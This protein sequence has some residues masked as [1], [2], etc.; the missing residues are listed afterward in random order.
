MSATRSSDGNAVFSAISHK[1]TCR[2]LSALPLIHD[3]ITTAVGISNMCDI[4]AKI[5]FLS[6][7]LDPQSGTN[8]SYV[9]STLFLFY[10]YLNSNGVSS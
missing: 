9:M 5:V 3:L 2:L 10:N 4:T 6:S 1:I 7:L 8:K